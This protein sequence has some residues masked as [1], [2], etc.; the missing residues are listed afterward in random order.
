[1][2]GP[3]T[4]ATSPTARIRPGADG[5]AAPRSARTPASPSATT[6]SGLLED[7]GPALHIV[8]G[9]G[10]GAAAGGRRPL[11]ARRARA[12]RPT[13]AGSPARG[14]STTARSATAGARCGC[15]RPAGGEG[16]RIAGGVGLPPGPGPRLVPGQPSP[17]LR[18]LPHDDDRPDAPADAGARRRRAPPS[19]S[20]R[21]STG[22]SATA[23]AA[24]RTSASA[25]VRCPWRRASASP[26]SAPAT[27]GPCRSSAC[28]S[29]A[30]AVEPVTPPGRLCVAEFSLGPGERLAY[31]A[32]DDV[33]AGPGLLPGPR[34]RA[35]PAHRGRRGASG[36]VSRAAPME[37]FTLPGRDGLEAEGWICR[38]AGPAAAPS[39]RSCTSMAGRTS[40][41]ATPLDFRHAL[42]LHAGWAVVFINPPGSSGYGHAFAAGAPR[43]LG[44]HR[45][46]VPDG[47][48][49]PLRGAGAGSAPTASR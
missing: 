1:M 4:A 14:W 3:P 23:R 21:T 43:R 36:A 2:P 6:R 31:T 38:P 24:T 34:R 49:G 29:A 48:A 9:R 22:S 19:R 25:A 46:P 16:R 35:A 47:G 28:R 15:S 27:A 10:R 40:S 33:H 18:Q 7:E 11:H 26:T 17:P 30:G 32:M 41:S 20:P 8:P 39:R 42:W 13:G 5:A 44:R 45:L 12:T 37:R